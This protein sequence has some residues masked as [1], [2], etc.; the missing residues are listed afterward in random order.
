M[1][2]YEQRTW[3]WRLNE[4]RWDRMRI[5]FDLDNTLIGTGN[6]L[7]KYVADFLKIEITDE[8]LLAYDYNL[9]YFSND[10]KKKFKDLAY[11]GIDILYGI[12]PERKLIQLLK[13]LREKHDLYIITA[14]SNPDVIEMTKY[15][16]NEYFGFFNQILFSHIKFDYVYDYEM[17]IFVDDLPAHVYDVEKNTNAKIFLIDKPYNKMVVDN[18]RI[19]RVKDIYDALAKIEEV[20]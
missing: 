20:E 18:D 13:Q 15:Y 2:R 7:I 19:T 6:Y 14:R 3:R 1:G 9:E 16:F 11:N 17:G 10:L 12:R 4:I 8:C 5:G